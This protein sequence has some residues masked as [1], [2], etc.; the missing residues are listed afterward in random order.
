[1]K[2]Y[3][4]LNGCVSKMHRVLYDAYDKGYAQGRKDY[5]RP[6]GEWKPFTQLRNLNFKCSNCGSLHVAY[7]KFC[8]SCG[9]QMEG[10]D[11][12]EAET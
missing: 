7:Y 4:N 11:H 5:E 9:A 3:R 8:P 6:S 2:H 1:M 12:A 10:V